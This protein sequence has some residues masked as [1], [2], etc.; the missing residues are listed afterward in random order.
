M[1]A[2]KNDD[3][4]F[5]NAVKPFEEYLNEKIKKSEDEESSA[6]VDLINATYEL[7]KDLQNTIMKAY[8]Q[9]ISANFDAGWYR[10]ELTT[11]KNMKGE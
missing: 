9:G 7:P 11:Y 5:N 2:I 10:R 4:Y 8:V 1:E 6:L 3:W